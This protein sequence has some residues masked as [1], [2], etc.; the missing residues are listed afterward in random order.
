MALAVAAPLRSAL[1]PAV[2]RR[3]IVPADVVYAVLGVVQSESLPSAL[4]GGA[5]VGRVIVGPVAAEDGGPL[6][7]YPP[8]AGIGPAGMPLARVGSLP[9][10]FL[11]AVLVCAVVVPAVLQRVT[12]VLHDLDVPRAPGCLAMPV[13]GTVAI[14]SVG[15]GGVCSGSYGLRT[16]RVSTCMSNTPIRLGVL[17]T[18]IGSTSMLDTV[19]GVQ[20]CVLDVLR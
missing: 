10:L 1:V 6:V 3:H 5:L 13:P 9:A 20:V 14:T 16:S 4:S 11:A 7:R 18:A 12:R 17:K 19:L 15:A 8:V 2:F